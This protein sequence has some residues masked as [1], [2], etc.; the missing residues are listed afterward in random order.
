MDAD[1]VDVFVV[2]GASGGVDVVGDLGDAIDEFVELVD[3]GLGGAFDGIEEVDDGGEAGGGFG[4]GAF[5]EAVGVG[6][7][8]V[9]FAIVLDVVVEKQG[10]V[11]E[12]LVVVLGFLDELV[13]RDEVDLA[14]EDDFEEDGGAADLFDGGGDEGLL[15]GSDG[16]A[17]AFTLG[18]LFEA[19]LVGL[20]GFED[21][22]FGLGVE[23][24]VIGHG[25]APV[26]GFE[27]LA[28]FVVDGVAF[29]EAFGEAE[30]AGG[31]FEKVVR[32]AVDGA[33]VEAEIAEAGLDAG[34]GG[35][36]VE[37]AEVEVAGGE[38]AVGADFYAAGANV[39][40][41]EDAEPA[42][43]VEVA[44][45]EGTVEGEDVG[46]VRERLVV[47]VEELEVELFGDAF[48]DEFVG[49][50]GGFGDLVGADGGD[51]E[52]VAGEE[53]VLMF[54]ELAELGVVAVLPD[55]GPVVSGFEG[56]LDGGFAL[57]YFVMTV[58]RVGHGVL[59]ALIYAVRGG[60]ICSSKE[61][62][63]WPTPDC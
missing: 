51:E 9:D 26:L 18:T 12:D 63:F 22:V 58:F 36:G 16:G 20:G 1:R 7:F 62:I 43:G 53:D 39:G 44:G 35:E 15:L 6:P 33:V 3:V 11:A 52:D 46:G 57:G 34:E 10:L 37:V 32:F 13:G 61:E 48:A 30:G 60:R 45:G 38:A 42:V 5:D 55:G 17:E 54:A 49:G 19:E 24:G 28:E 27:A 21:V 56:E 59:G 40:T 25:L 23:Q 47:V 2:E 4:D 50:V 41:D 29:G 8:L 31:F 14:V